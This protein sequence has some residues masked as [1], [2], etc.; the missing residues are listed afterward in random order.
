MPTT[1]TTL[2]TRA[3]ATVANV[4]ANGASG[5]IARCA[6]GHEALLP[7]E[8]LHSDRYVPDIALR[9]RCTPKWQEARREFSTW[10]ENHICVGYKAAPASI[11]PTSPRTASGKPAPMP[12]ALPHS[13]RSGAAPTGW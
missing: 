12:S 7:F 11:V 8:L 6:C 3:P 1:S 13:R 9:L 5:I 10:P 4:R 2:T